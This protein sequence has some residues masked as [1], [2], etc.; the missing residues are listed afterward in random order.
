MPG[1][2]ITQVCPQCQMP[3]VLPASFLGKTVPCSR[4]GREVLVESNGKPV[5]QGTFPVPPTALAPHLVGGAP[6]AVRP[7]HLDRQ[8]RS[9][10]SPAPA[11]VQ[12]QDLAIE[13]PTAGPRRRRSRSWFVAGCLLLGVLA[14]C[15][16]AI[17]G[18]VLAGAWFVTPLDRP[19]TTPGEGAL[20]D[21]TDEAGDLP[22][23]TADYTNAARKSIAYTGVL[24][25][26]DNV[27]VG[28]VDYR[29][30]REFFRTETPDYL[31]VTLSV[32]NKD[33]GRDVEYRSWYSYQFE[34][35]EEGPQQVEL[36]DEDGLALEV[37]PI[38]DAEIVERHRASDL[39]IEPGEEIADS[40][41]F[42]LPPDYIDDAI[43]PL[44]LKLPAAAI[45]EKG[46]FRF[47]IPGTMIERRE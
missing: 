22:A 37:F 10:G 27:Q 2:A 20:A 33:R 17:V 9:A 6:L 34:D 3:L 5:P 47:Y 38:K 12:P 44:Y 31:I 18:L 29:A 41:V 23:K 45:G 46:H 13:T 24:V 35:D 30:E 40:V 15:S 14:V 7:P 1:Q 42:K 8:D 32:K 11:P 43:P 19:A 16:A 26:V 28:K 21:T 25:R 36:L 39:A 4:C